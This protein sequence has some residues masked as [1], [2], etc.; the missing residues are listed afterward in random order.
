M[1]P[2]LRMTVARLLTAI[3][4]KG[5]GGNMRFF[6][7]GTAVAYWR[8][9]EDQ[10]AYRAAFAAALDAAS[11][12]PVD[13][14]LM[15]AYGVPAVRHGASANMPVAGSYSLLAPVLGYPAGVVPVTRVAAGEDL[16]RAKSSDLVQKTASEA[17]LGSAGLPVA[18]QLMGRPWRD[19]VVLAAMRV[20][21]QAARTRPDY[22]ATP[23]I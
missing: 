6:A 3:G 2:A 17:D 15:P 18:V 14:I 22:P 13:L 7:D 12:G 19:D 5:L 1:P 21:E 10:A 9:V 8:A 23:K 11:G 4:Q 16:G 20:I